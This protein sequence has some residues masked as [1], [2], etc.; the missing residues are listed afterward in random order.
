[1]DLLLND[2]FAFFVSFSNVFVFFNV[3]AMCFLLF[4]ISLKN[5]ESGFFSRLKFVFLFHSLFLF[6]VARKTKYLNL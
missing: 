4:S 3:P 5:V 2:V 1:M 6:F